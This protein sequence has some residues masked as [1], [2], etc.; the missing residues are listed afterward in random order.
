[1]RCGT[2]SRTCSA[3]GDIVLFEYVKKNNRET[4]PALVGI[5]LA[6]ADALADLLA[7]M[8]ASPLAI[9]KLAP[10][11]PVFEFLL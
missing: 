11:S 1:M 10:D 3:P 2:S 7:K 8:D 4:G 9:D 6:R 5:D